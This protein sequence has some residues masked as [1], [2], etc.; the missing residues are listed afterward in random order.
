MAVLRPIRIDID[1]N[2]NP[3]P[4]IKATQVFVILGQAF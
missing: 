4:G 3:N 1:H 2:L